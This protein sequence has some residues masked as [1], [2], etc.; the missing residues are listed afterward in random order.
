MPTSLE[1]NEYTRF[2][3]KPLAN[4]QDGGCHADVYLPV[5]SDKSAA[6]PVA[7][8]YH[9]GGFNIGDTHHLFTD[10]VGYLL[11]KGF[12]VVSAEYRMAPHARFTEIREDLLDSYKWCREKLG[13]AA[14]CKIDPSRIIVFGGSAGGTASIFLVADALKAGIPPPKAMYVIYPMVDDTFPVAG[15]AQKDYGSN[16][17]GH[18]N[19]LEPEERKLL[20]EMMAGPAATAYNIR[21]HMNDRSPTGR[22][23]WATIAS[24]NSLLNSYLR[25]DASIEHCPLKLLSSAFPPSVIVKAL[26]D[27]LLPPEHCD[28]M[29]GKLV[30]LGVETKL[31]EAKD[32]EHGYAEA[33]REVWPKGVRWWEE[34]YAPALDFCIKHCS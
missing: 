10:H 25:G 18:L 34:V 13:E 20:D 17:D 4:C 29:Y 15:V 12:A 26:A 14:G 28:V 19:N 5:S 32:M 7:L 21:D 11:Q 3:F 8:T 27:K 16:Y 31:L 23:I 2:L 22:Q 1:G 33:P 9:G 30:E 24:Q 6:Y